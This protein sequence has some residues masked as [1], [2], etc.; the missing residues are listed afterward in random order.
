MYTNVVAPISV[1]TIQPFNRKP[2]MKLFL[3]FHQLCFNKII[4]SDAL[5]ERKIKVLCNS[6]S[7]SPEVWILDANLKPISWIL[8]E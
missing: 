2:C 8:N 6:G 3:S 7:V 5:Q 1:C 4:N